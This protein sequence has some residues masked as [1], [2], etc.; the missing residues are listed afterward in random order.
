[1][2]TTA[3]MEKVARDRKV[4]EMCMDLVLVLLEP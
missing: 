4:K 1:M 2:L 3:S